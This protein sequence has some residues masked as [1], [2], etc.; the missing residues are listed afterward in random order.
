MNYTTTKEVV[1]KSYPLRFLK[2][3]LQLGVAAYLGWMLYYQSGYQREELG[4]GFSQVLT[5]GWPSFFLLQLDDGMESNSIGN[6]YSTQNDGSQVVWDTVDVGMYIHYS[7]L[8]S[9]FSCTC[10][11]KR[12]F[13][14]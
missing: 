7:H 13:V 12:G 5:T 3:V 9:Y 11:R 1:V 14:F 8:R 10:K 2:L 6:A 4:F